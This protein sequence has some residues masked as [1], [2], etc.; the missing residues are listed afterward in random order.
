M[1]YDNAYDHSDTG[2]EGLPPEAGATHIGM[3]LAWATLAGLGNPDAVNA[4]ALET[5]TLTPGKW[6]FA[7]QDGKF[8][9][10]ALSDE[11]N[12]FALDYYQ[13]GYD[14]GGSL[15]M[16][17]YM[18]AFDNYFEESIYQVPDNWTSYDE[19]APMIDS[20]YL[21]WRNAR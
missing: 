18:V 11:G 15:Y 14:H 6:L 4:T 7:T 13:E 5:R 10:D 9:S 21:K 1:L 19:I 16:E 8:V 12:A 20:A 2:V 17:D 3:F